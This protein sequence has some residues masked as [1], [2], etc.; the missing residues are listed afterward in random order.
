MLKR[1][2]IFSVKYCQR[3]DKKM[4]GKNHAGHSEQAKP[5]GS[6]PKIRINVTPRSIR[7]FFLPFY[8]FIWYV[9]RHNV[10]IP[11][12]TLFSLLNVL[13]KFRNAA[14]GGLWKYFSRWSNLA[15]TKFLRPIRVPVMK[16]KFDGVSIR[17]FS[18]FLYSD[19][20]FDD[21]I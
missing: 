12:R 13:G 3:I 8:A 21:I 2:F 20:M 19:I 16:Y 18:R 9:W 5:R 1:R 7:F 4:G 15:V 17:N 11:A 6:S 10:R 14:H